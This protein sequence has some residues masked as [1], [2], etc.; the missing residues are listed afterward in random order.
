MGFSIRTN[1]LSVFL[2]LL[3][4]TFPPVTFATIIN[5]ESTSAGGLPSDNQIIGLGDYFMADG[6]SVSFGFDTTGDGSADEVGRFEKA[7]GGKESGNSGFKSAYGSQYDIAATG[8]ESLLGEFFL[9]QK[10]AYE[11]FG[12]FHIM[13]D[14]ENPVTAASGEIW[15]I[16]G[17]AGN[18]EQFLITAF[19][20]I[21]PLASITSPLGNNSTLDGKPW[22]FGFTDLSNIT[23][24]EITFT[25]SKTKGIGLAFNNFSPIEDVSAAS[26]S[27]PEPSILVIFLLAL[28]GLIF[29]RAKS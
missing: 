16:D 25:G 19:N 27:V 12:T 8:F 22:A 11:P 23:S 7:G 29:H 2:L 9:R 20:G 5:F 15:D 14:A 10:D 1:I 21:T 3:S 18:T 17:R 24:I 13:Y 6:V 28:I 4:I 26:N